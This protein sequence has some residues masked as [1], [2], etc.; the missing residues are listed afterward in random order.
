MKCSILPSF[1]L[2]GPTSEAITRDVFSLG[3]TVALA[4]GLVTACQQIGTNGKS[5]CALCI[6]Y[7]VK[8]N[9]SC[10]M[11]DNIHSSR[12]DHVQKV[13]RETLLNCP[14]VNIREEDPGGIH[15]LLVVPGRERI[16]ESLASV[17]PIPGMARSGSVRIQK[18][19]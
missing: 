15:S 5:A 2:S 8:S 3:E 7:H 18:T 17:A 19:I 4:S 16:A 6:F 9:F 10:D 13:R 11:I 12:G 14:S 1:F